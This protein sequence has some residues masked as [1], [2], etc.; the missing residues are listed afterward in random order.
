MIK[1]VRRWMIYLMQ[2]W[3]MASEDSTSKRS[4][5]TKITSVSVS[6]EFQKLIAQYNLSPTECFRRGIAVTLCDLGVGMYQSQKNEERLS[7]MNEF[8]KK[9]D[10]DENAKIM[11]KDVEEIKDLQIEI[12]RA[13]QKVFDLAIKHGKDPYF[14]SK[15]ED[16]KNG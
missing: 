13:S 15:V 10:E 8:L 11:E 4:G 14:K 7:Y 5:H 12:K 16:I 3:K 9:I 6:N 2:R 1:R